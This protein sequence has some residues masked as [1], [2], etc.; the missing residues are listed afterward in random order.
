MG[1]SSP[2]SQIESQAADF[3]NARN[4]L[5][6]RDD[7]AGIGAL[8]KCEIVWMEKS[9]T[10]IGQNAIAENIQKRGLD[11][12]PLEIRQNTNRQNEIQ[13][14]VGGKLY[15]QVVTDAAIRLEIRVYFR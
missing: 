10:P 11:V 3:L 12:S 1:V 6:G 8:T 14:N 13:W 7:S 2:T 5:S 15:F 9:K 4:D